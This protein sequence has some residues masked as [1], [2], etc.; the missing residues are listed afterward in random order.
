MVSSPAAPTTSRGALLGLSRAGVVVLL[1]LAAANGLFLYL[2]PGQAKAHYAWSI[3]PPASAAFLGAGFL[4]GTVPTAIVVFATERWRSLRTLPW[5]LFVLAVSLLIAT[6]VHNDRFKWTYPPTWGWAA[7]YGLVPFGV[8]YLWT[9]QERV[10]EPEPDADPALR[11]LR[12][13]S[14]VLGGLVVL[15]A[16]ALFLTPVGLGKHWPWQL[17]PLLG[18][19]VSPWYAMI[20]VILLA[21]AV[22][23][24]T[25]AEALIPYATVLA[26][27]VL[28]ALIP[29]LHSADV[30]RDG[31]EVAFYVV[32]AALLGV[33]AWG[34]V[35]SRVESPERR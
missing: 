19:A 25:R 11:G 8:V 26:W 5:A 31:P 22:S 14:G 4:A 3:S 32:M 18:R 15:G 9:R 10:A 17:T 23:L 1:V 34:L 28:V 13:V 33:S 35:A 24:R 29:V 16:L 27:S 7:V 2:F 20:G 6:I 30:I 21:C 12:I